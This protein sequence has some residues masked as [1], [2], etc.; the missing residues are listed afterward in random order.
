MTW[1]KNSKASRTNTKIP[2]AVHLD[3]TARVQIIDDQSELVIARILSELDNRHGVKALVNTSMNVRGEPICETLADSLNCFKSAGLDF[4]IVDGYILYRNE[5]NPLVM[6][7][8]STRVGI[9]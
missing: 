1:L 2:S 6:A 5:Q 7:N 8:F 9:D 3:G 4:L